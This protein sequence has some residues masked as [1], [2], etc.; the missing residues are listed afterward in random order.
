MSEVKRNTLLCD[1]LKLERYTVRSLSVQIQSELYSIIVMLLSHGGF[2]R[3]PSFMDRC[4]RNPSHS[5]KGALDRLRWLTPGIVKDL[6]SCPEATL[7]QRY[8]SSE[9]P[10]HL[11]PYLLDV[12]RAE[13]RLKGDRDIDKRLQQ[14]VKFKV[15]TTSNKTD[16]RTKLTVKKTHQAEKEEADISIVLDPPTTPVDKTEVAKV[17]ASQASFACKDVRLKTW[18]AQRESI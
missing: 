6:G 16:L 13:Q 9:L 10:L 11:K 2:I 18:S 4:Y 17:D 8:R 7:R 12:P 3:V 14:A 15:T 5:V 1:F